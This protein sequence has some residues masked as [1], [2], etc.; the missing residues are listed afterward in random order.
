MDDIE[1]TD[2]EILKLQ[3]NESA[4]DQEFGLSAMECAY[5]AGIFQREYVVQGPVNLCSSAKPADKAAFEMWTTL[6]KQQAHQTTS[7]MEIDGGSANPNAVVDYTHSQGGIE[8]R[9]HGPTTD[10]N[11]MKKVLNHEQA[12]AHD[13]VTNHLL[14]TVNNQ[15]PPQLRMIL[16]GPGGTGKTVVIQAI[17]ETFAELG[18]TAQL[19][20][21]ATSGVAA[22]LISG[23]TLHSWA[24]LP[25]MVPRK[26]NWTKGS[27]AIE[28]RRTHNMKSAQYLVIDEI[29][30]ATKDLLAM[31][32]IITA[33]VRTSLQI[34]GHELFF[35]GL[36]VILC[37][38]FHQFP[39]VGNPT[40]A[41]YDR[42][43][44]EKPK[45]S[46]FAV[47]GY[48]VYEAFDRVVTLKQQMRVQDVGWLNMLE[49]LR[50]G[51]CNREDIDLLH[52]IRL[53]LPANV[54]PDMNSGGWQAAVL[55][56]P[57]HSARKRWN[58][59]AV[60]RLCAL[61]SER[62]YSAPAEDTSKG[63]V[64]PKDEQATIAKRSVKDTANLP[65]RVEV[66]I[67]MKVMVV[68]NIAT[69]SDLANGTRG[70]VV[71]II[72]DERE[73]STLKETGG[74]TLLRYPLAAV[75]IRPDNPTDTELPGLAHG[76][77][78]IMPSKGQ[79][80]IT[81][82]QGSRRTISRM[83]TAITPGYAFTDY[84][85]QGQT[86]EHVIVDLRAPIGGQG[87]TPF[88]AYVALS[89]S[90]GRHTIRLLR[91]FDEKN[92]V[93]HPSEELRREDV[94]LDKLSADTEKTWL[95]GN[96]FMYT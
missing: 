80:V 4:R 3:D 76:I 77:L 30:M 28:Q 70:T 84:K 11:R 35:G 50:T 31:V 81:D 54:H 23:Q 5:E 46:R 34:E 51:S 40:G 95:E 27:P 82:G 79:F 59:A 91:G 78:P 18:V 45:R 62:L 7:P 20:K 73:D 24:G 57:R 83:Q 68:L 72:L 17:T 36:N 47:E 8:A 19:A 53:D 33:T 15:H 10:T 48:E 2:E 13:I 96:R 52:S 93:T 86:M 37:G 60:R 22:T 9:N 69:E 74:V 64:V 90:R 56:T 44:Q 92:F 39:P 58:A 43:F 71:D 41:L 38:D 16:R 65:H 14:A 55:I 26:D 63:C 49:R 25:I 21:T 94:R 12:L 32:H 29:S 75:L 61:T 66:A 88:G 67:G 87:I 1:W 6:L 85:G 42:S 89:R